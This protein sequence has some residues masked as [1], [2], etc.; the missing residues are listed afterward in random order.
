MVL[1]P[2]SNKKVKQHE[3]VFQAFGYTLDKNNY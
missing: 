3:E 1:D 2:N